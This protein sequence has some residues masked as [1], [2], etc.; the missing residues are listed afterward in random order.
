[1]TVRSPA[2]RDI[3][4]QP[5]QQMKLYPP[6]LIPE[7][8]HHQ[9]DAGKGANRIDS[10]P[11]E[12]ERVAVPNHLFSMFFDSSSIR[13]FTALNTSSACFD[14]STDGVAESTE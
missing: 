14:K 13:C 9:G 8:K 7:G 2:V 1:M 5:Y 4:G 3:P 6:G 11:L 12:K 10:S